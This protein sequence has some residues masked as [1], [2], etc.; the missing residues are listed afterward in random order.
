MLLKAAKLIN[1]KGSG[2]VLISIGTADGQ[3]VTAIIEKINNCFHF[4]I[5]KPSEVVLLRVS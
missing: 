5:K 4:L 2:H 1:P 3:G